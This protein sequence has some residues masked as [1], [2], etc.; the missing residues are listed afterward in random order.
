MKI[1]KIILGLL[2]CSLILSS[3]STEGDLPVR[4][5][6]NSVSFTASVGAPL[7]RATATKWEAN[8]AI[9]VYALNDGQQLT[10]GVYDSKENIKYTTTSTGTSGEFTV[11]DASQTIKLPGNGNK[12][13]F[14]AYYPYSQNVTGYK[15]GVDVSS[16]T[17]L[18]AI[19][20]LYATKAGITK[21][22]PTVNLTFNHKLSR[23]VIALEKEGTISLDNAEVTFKNAITDAK[24]VLADGTVEKGTNTADVSANMD[25]TAHTA[26]A[27]LIP[28]QKVADLVVEIKLADGKMYKWTPN[29][30][31]YVLESGKSAKY[32]L[33]LTEG[34]VDANVNGN[35]INDWDNATGNGTGSGTLDPQTTS[36]TAD[37]QELSFTSDAGSSDIAITANPTTITWTATSDQTWATLGSANGTGSG[38]LAVNVTKNDTTAERTAIITITPSKGNAITVKVKQAGVTSPNTPVVLFPGSDFNDWATFESSVEEKDTSVKKSENE[39]RGGSTALH[40]QGNPGNAY[41]FKTRVPSNFT[42][43]ASKIIFYIKGSSVTKSLSIN[44][45]KKDGSSV[46]FNLL[47]YTAEKILAPKGGNSY[48]GEIN[49][50]NNWLKVTL[51][52]SSISNEIQTTQGELLFALKGSTGGTYDLYIDD[53]T[54]E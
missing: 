13:D 30:A 25:N 2:G 22:S 41:L 32:T 15:V 7:T 37:K 14:I 53:I 44:L 24:L 17:D 49:T 29:T 28:G 6:E 20:F 18:T 42:A 10:T 31:D 11:A 4:Q 52:V 54:V 43:P 9:G 35:S 3:C 40:I 38:S 48:T 12:I 45:F 27:I 33:T 34:N 36:F 19:D 46:K 26:T 50:A 47:S 21:S 16:Q 1:K 51:D 8:D 39:G 23:V 5:E